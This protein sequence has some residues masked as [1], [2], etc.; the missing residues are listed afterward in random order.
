MI[1]GALVEKA[2][3]HRVGQSSQSTGTRI[4][5]SSQLRSHLFVRAHNKPIEGEHSQAGREFL[6]IRIPNSQFAL[7]DL[8]LK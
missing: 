2:L 3:A 8:I 1:S 6:L 4:V 5:D 7:R